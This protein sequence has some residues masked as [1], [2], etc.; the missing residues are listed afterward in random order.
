V[1]KDKEKNMNMQVKKDIFLNF[2]RDIASGC[3][4]KIQNE[5][6]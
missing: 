2:A 3:Y 6:S 4:K 5:A 1:C